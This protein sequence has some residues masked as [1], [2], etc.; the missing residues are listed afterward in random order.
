MLRFAVRNLLSRPVRSLLSLLGLTVAI[1]GMVGLF[2]VAEGIDATVD[3]TFGQIPGIL[4]MQKGAPIPLFS[5]IPKTWAKE[6]EELPGVNVVSAEIW[7]RVNVINGKNIVSPPRFL[8]GADI[9]AHQKLKHSVYGKAIIEGRYLNESDK[10]LPRTVISRQIAEEFEVGV[11][12]SITA[13]GADFEVVGIYYCGSLLLD[14]AVIVDQPIV[15]QMSLFDPG[16]VCSFYVEPTGE[17]SNEKIV[18]WMQDMFR[19]RDLASWQPMSLLLGSGLSSG[20]SS[21][22][23][24]ATS[25]N[26]LIDLV[27]S[28][29]SAIKSLGSS[30]VDEPVSQTEE[31]AA[32]DGPS[33]ISMVN[34]DA[35]DV[36]SEVPEEELDPLEIRSAADWAERFDEFTS[37]LDIFLTIMT[38][39]GLTIAVLSIINTM[40]MSVSERIIEFGI[41]K[42][43]GWSRSDVMKL[44]TY[45]SAVLGVAGGICGTS[46]GWVLTLIINW[47]WPEHIR[48]LASPELLTFSVVF[49]TILGILG[50]LYPALWATRMM[51]MDAI[52][53]G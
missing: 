30:D 50:G 1:V 39:I 7:V 37:D 15:R 36:A 33:I 53:R 34:A 11:G 52:R 2:S 26:P 40:L 48:L 42:A 10:G 16:V 43:N 3:D 25:G 14:M 23:R 13:N 29:D 12:D 22:S 4:V 17:I 32:D 24:G 45:E 8:F 21:K 46:S 31:Q 41:L 44:I 18:E 28:A 5:R 49:A 19:G 9:L 38:S 51:P 27:R 20:T 35:E 47:R 6:I